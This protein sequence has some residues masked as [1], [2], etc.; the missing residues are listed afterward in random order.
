MFNAFLECCWCGAAV[1][2]SEAP[3]CD[4]LLTHYP[5]TCLP[6]QIN[7]GNFQF[8]I[9]CIT[10]QLLWFIIS[11]ILIIIIIIIILIIIYGSAAQCGLWPPVPRGFVITHIDATQSGRTPLD[12]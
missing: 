5:Q 8:S 12:K 10:V 11:I 3:F 6:T 4:F 9:P 2:Y 1:V 7:A